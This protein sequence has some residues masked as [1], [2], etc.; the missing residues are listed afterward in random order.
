MTVL[1]VDDQPDVV[2]GEQTGIDWDRLGI[3]RILT[4]YNVS[5]A[6]RV[7]LEHPV[8]ILLC[9]IEMPPRSGMELLELIRKK[10]LHTRCIFLTAHAEFSYA[11][12][13]VQLGGFDYILQPAPYSEI[14]AAVVRAAADLKGKTVQPTMPVQSQPKDAVPPTD[15]SS[16]AQAIDYIRQ[17]PDRELTRAQV[18][19]AV[20][21]NPEY[22][23]RLFKKKTGISLHDFI[24]R[25]KMERAKSMLKDTDIPIGLVAMRIGYTNFSYFS[26]VF[27]RYIGMTPQEYRSR[28]RP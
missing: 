5:D 17:N 4:A 1:I 10:D 25:E 2:R 28:A 20:Y 18:A 11:Q 13:A 24:V 21:L 19:E 26:Q 27:R 14:E 3:D 7:L 9:D 22:L 6:E 23:S 8:D 15:D 16:I 12:K